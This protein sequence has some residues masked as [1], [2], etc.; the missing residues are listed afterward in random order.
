MSQLVEVI[1]AQAS[2]I[3]EFWFDVDGVMTPQGAITIFDVCDDHGRL[4]HFVR[5]QEGLA[6]VTLVPCDDAG[7][8]IANVVESLAG[9]VADDGTVPVWEGYRFDPRDGK[10]VEYLVQAGY[11]VHFISGRDSACVRDRA[12]KLK[13]VPHLGIKDKLPYIKQHALCLPSEI[14]FIGDG[15]QD[16]EVLGVAGVAIAPKDA[17]PEALAAAHAVTEAK[18]GEGVLSETL[19]IFLKV[20]G[21]WPA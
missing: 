18:G 6:S 3:K 14:L 16:C 4:S 8:P 7:R 1:S 9:Y 13:A 12:R 15:I 21:L 11:K 10:V 20:R 17:C 19:T 5:R 2:A